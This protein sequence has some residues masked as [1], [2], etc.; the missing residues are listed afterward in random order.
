MRPILESLALYLANTPSKE[1]A[2]TRIILPN[3]RAGLFLQ[4]NLSRHNTSVSWTPAICAINDFIS[5]LSQLDLCDPVEAV[6]NAA[7]SP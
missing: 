5:E 7:R 4:R 3:R 2:R 1:S 6:F